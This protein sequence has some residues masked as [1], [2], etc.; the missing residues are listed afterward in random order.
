M[1]IWQTQWFLLLG[2]SLGQFAY[3]VYDFSPTASIGLRSYAP[4]RLLLI[5]GCVQV[6]LHLVML[7]LPWFQSRWR[8]LPK[9]Q[10]RHVHQWVVTLASSVLVTL[11]VLDLF[12]MA[13]TAPAPVLLGSTLFAGHLFGVYF[14]LVYIHYPYVDHL[15][16]NETQPEF[17][18]MHWTWAQQAR[19]TTLWMV[20][21]LLFVVHQVDSWLLFIGAVPGIWSSS[22]LDS[23]NNSTQID[24]T[25]PFRNHRHTL[26][27]PSP[28]SLVLIVVD[29]LGYDSLVGH[30]AWPIFLDSLEPG[31]CQVRVS[32]AQVPTMSI[33]NWV[34]LV[35]G[36][37]T[38]W[39]GVQGNILLQ[40]VYLDTLFHRASAMDPALSWP[41]STPAGSW[42]NRTLIGSDWFE[43]IIP[44]P[45]AQHLMSTPTEWNTW[46][47]SSITQAPLPFPFA[48][49]AQ[50]G[51]IG[52]LIRTRWAIETL[53]QQNPPNLLL[54]HLESVD[55]TGHQYGAA[56]RTYRDAI[57]LSLGLI[58]QVLQVVS[59]DT[60]VWI[61]ADH[62][63]TARGGHGGA[64][65]D[66]TRVP[67]VS[68]YRD[69]VARR[70]QS[71]AARQA[72]L[73]PELRS[74]FQQD[75]F[76][77]D[78]EEEQDTENN[79]T[80][81]VSSLSV[82]ESAAL[83]LGLQAPRQAQGTLFAELGFL[84]PPSFWQNSSWRIQVWLDRYRQRRQ[85]LLWAKV[86][87]G[88]SAAE[89]EVWEKQFPSLAGL[90]T[91][92]DTQE[93]LHVLNEEE[94]ELWLW[95]ACRDLEQEARVWSHSSLVWQTVRSVTCGWALVLL[96]LGWY[97]HV[98]REWSWT[99]WARLYAPRDFYR[100]RRTAVIFLGLYLGLTIA[101]YLLVMVAGLGYPTWDSTQVH[102]PIV[103][104]RYMLVTVLPGAL[105]FLVG[106]RR[107][108]VPM[109][110]HR[111]NS[112]REPEHAVLGLWHAVF[113]TVFFTR[114]NWVR[115]WLRLL[116]Y[117]T[118]LLHVSLLAMLLLLGLESVYRFLIPWHGF[119]WTGH[120]LFWTY[121]FRIMTI[122]W[123][124][125]PWLIG[126]IWEWYSVPTWVQNDAR[127]L[128]GL[129]RIWE[130][131]TTCGSDVDSN[132]EKKSVPMV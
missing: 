130:Q 40:D 10:H 32:T 109:L 35:S 108:T 25:V 117:R 43:R 59:N 102:S 28:P 30:E 39:T 103:W 46:L 57:E 65:P 127:N 80:R 74:A 37:N 63:H 2:L 61:T 52:D 21:F 19:W 36:A 34:T 62:G 48:L 78:D 13:P 72:F 98:A 42:M 119:V 82:A 107:I 126:V 106:N 87:V 101:V 45:D 96:M 33:P 26:V 114:N 88:E 27:D 112:N 124:L 100:A 64:T 76:R 120:A 118:W 113:H 104:S 44:F 38:D 60:L 55:H 22:Q 92:S 49:E 18:S 51:H 81:R 116:L 83:W 99:H 122:E 31:A 75:W 70:V 73:S 5:L 125:V 105:V 129:K 29:G 47:D 84:L 66:L 95:N 24:S 89:V 58:R 7:S 11:L 23:M 90:S 12:L 14:F 77:V 41:P 16:R 15:D 1:Y 9:H 54:L 68:Y 50:H 6:T 110:N 94:L 79:G 67:L 115:S 123:M 56:S 86:Q 3:L 121:Q 131:G 128:R 85:S 71:L 17:F 20:I 132:E 4:P 97:R 91:V 8:Q 93:A 111:A 53:T 69:R